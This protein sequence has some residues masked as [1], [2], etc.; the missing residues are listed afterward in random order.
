[1]KQILISGRV[2]GVSFRYNVKEK[3]DE[4]GLKGWVKNLDDGRVEVVV[5]KPEELIKLCKDFQID[6]IEIKEC[7]EHC[8]DFKIKI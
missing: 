1:M 4:H 2:Q 5:D 7:Q 3:A 8:E 6:T